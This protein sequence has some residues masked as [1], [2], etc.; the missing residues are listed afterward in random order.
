MIAELSVIIPTLN[1]ERYLPNLLQSIANQHFPP[2]LQIIVVDG[3]SED[4]TVEVGK[5]FKKQIQDLTIIESKRDIGS[6]RNSGVKLAKYDH[7]LFIDADIVLPKNLFSRFLRQIKPEEQ[8]VDT[9]TLR[10]FDGTLLENFFFTFAYSIMTILSFL[11]PAV[12]GS[13]LFTTKKLHNEIHGFK[14]G[15]LMGEDLDYGK[16]LVESG[17]RYHMHHTLFIYHSA[18]R[19]KGVGVMKLLL[20]YARTY[21]YY[22]RHGVIYKNSGFSYPYGKY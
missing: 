13:F 20:T 5:K 11:T 18:R 16:R 7:I 22:L 9:V 15:V 8:R 21:I 14:E 4:M 2:K 10:V 3:L 1:E 17:A 19:V 6:Q 12:Y